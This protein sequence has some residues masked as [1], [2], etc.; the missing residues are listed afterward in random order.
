MQNVFSIIQI[1]KFSFHRGVR[2]K[3]SNMCYACFVDASAD[4]GMQFLL[5]CRNLK[6]KSTSPNI[7]EWHKFKI[8]TINEWNPCG[9]CWSV[10][11]M[12]L[13]W[14]RGFYFPLPK[15]GEYDLLLNFGIFGSASQNLFFCFSPLGEI[16][17]FVIQMGFGTFFLL[18]KIGRTSLFILICFSLFSSELG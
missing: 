6:A 4:T 1:P 8:V 15:D 3:P 12:E 9:S 5:K 14:A 11:I 2:L 18:R 16:A 13:R 10:V 17:T 7:H